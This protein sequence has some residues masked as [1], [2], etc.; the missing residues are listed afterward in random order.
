M[1]NE[2]EP[3]NGKLPPREQTMTRQDFLKRGAARALGILAGGG[4]AG[5]LAA[6]PQINRIYPGAPASRGQKLRAL[7]TRKNFVVMGACDSATAKLMEAAGVEAAFL[8][9]SNVGGRWTNLADRGLT[10][11]TESL[12]IAKYIAEAV[13]FPLIFDGDTGHGGPFMVKRLVHECIKL[14]LGGIRIDDQDIEMKRTTG[15]EGIIVA[16][17]EVVIARYKAASDARNEL[18]PD[19]VIQAQVYTR[20]AANGGMAEFLARVPLYEAAGCDWIHLAGAQS[21]DEV[22]Q[23]R[24]V[25]KKHFSAMGGQWGRGLTVQQHGDMGLACVWNS[26]WPAS[27]ID[28]ALTAALADYKKRGPLVLEDPRRA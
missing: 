17:R 19:F 23:G 25:S 27:A 9:T 7:L 15:N 2:N 28:R 24:A 14:G 12:T 16:S 18:D 10:T 11:A 8:G 22:K 5:N 13:N 1:A 26:G 21:V 6:A 3:I 20:E 4:A